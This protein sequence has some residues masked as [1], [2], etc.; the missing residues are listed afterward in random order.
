MKLRIR[1]YLILAFIFVSVIPLAVF[2]SWPYSRILEAEKAEVRE[3]HLLI[4]ENLASVLE[5]YHRDLVTAL[6]A[7]RESIEA[8]RGMEARTLFRNLSFRHICVADSVTG[9][10]RSSYLTEEAPCPAEV[11]AKRLALFRE[12]AASSPPG[13]S[14]VFRPEGEKPR[15]FLAS[16]SGDNLIVAAV[17]TDFFERLRRQV[18]FGEDGHAAIVD[19]T[20][21]IL[22]HP[23]SDTGKCI[24]NVGHLAPVE[25]IRN[26]E[27]GV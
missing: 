5:H 12:L 16:R 4:A 25:R 9:V 6:A 21:G 24:D 18:R 26:G 10:V 1:T 13:V 23:C 22:A 11:P 15:I 8:G 2:W 14:R 3:R 20:G 7:F 19:Q 27:S 17:Y